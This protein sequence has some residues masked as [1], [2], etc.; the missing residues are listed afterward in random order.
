MLTLR[1][2]HVAQLDRRPWRTTSCAVDRAPRPPSDRGCRLSMRTSV[3]LPEP[4]NPITTKTS[5]WAT[6]NETSRT[7]ATH[8]V[9]ASSSPRGRSASGVPTMRVGLGAVDLPHV[10]TRDRGVRRLGQGAA[11]P[12]GS[13]PRRAHRTDRPIV[14]PPAH[15]RKSGVAEPTTAN[16]DE[17]RQPRPSTSRPEH[18]E[19]RCPR[20]GCATGRSCRNAIESATAIRGNTAEAISTIDSRPSR[21]ADRVRHDAEQVGGARDD[22]EQQSGVPP[23]A[24]ELAATDERQAGEHREPARTGTPRVRA[25]S[26]PPVR[27]SRGG[28]HRCR[29]APPRRSPTAARAAAC[30]CRPEASRGRSR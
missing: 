30:A 23:D 2:A 21:R 24:I 4:D 3:D 17:R 1:A 18:D 5:P 28:S 15:A 27:S 10:A 14:G 22:G 7:A 19:A 25:P 12:L 13:G 29:T 20:T 16:G 26:R 11:P 9:F 8:P 6:S